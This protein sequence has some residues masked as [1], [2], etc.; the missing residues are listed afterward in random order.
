MVGFVTV[1][2]LTIGSYYLVYDEADTGVVTESGIFKMWWFH[3]F[4]L[5]GFAIFAIF[6][7]YVFIITIKKKLNREALPSERL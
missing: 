2:L 7:L 4:M 3:A 5:V 1:V 6:Y